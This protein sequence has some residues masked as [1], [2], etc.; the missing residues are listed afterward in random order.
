MTVAVISDDCFAREHQLCG[1][2]KCPKPDSPFFLETAIAINHQVDPYPSLK[3]CKVQHESSNE[4]N[5][6]QAGEVDSKNHPWRDQWDVSEIKKG[7]H[8]WMYPNGRLRTVECLSKHY[9]LLEWNKPKRE[10]A[11]RIIGLLPGDRDGHWE[12]MDDNDVPPVMPLPAQLRS[13]AGEVSFWRGTH[14]EKLPQESR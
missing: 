11:R 6:L 4:A 5:E 1:Q 10:K 8:Y 13:T 3:R 7:S 2:K 14:D 12:Y 9:L